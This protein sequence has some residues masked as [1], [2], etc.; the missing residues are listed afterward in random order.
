[1][2]DKYMNVGGVDEGGSYTDTC[3]LVGSYRLTRYVD[4]D[5]FAAYVSHYPELNVS[6]PE[7]T[8]IKFD[9][10]V[11]DSANISNLD[12]ETGY[13][14]DKAF[15]PSGHIARFCRIAIVSLRRRR[16]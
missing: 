8:M 11:S 3:A 14:Y 13:E 16:A 2:L 9:D 15:V 4:D 7:Y 5:T 1:M 12:N 10:S 6:Q